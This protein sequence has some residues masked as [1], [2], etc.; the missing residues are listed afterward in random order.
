MN[1]F[2][3]I[4]EVT[5]NRI[6]SRSDSADIHFNFASSNIRRRV[7]LDETVSYG[8]SEKDLTIS[9]TDK[10]AFVWR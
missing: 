5:I 3:N 1:S 10:V 6:Y 7:K 9:I 8:R 4:R 2:I